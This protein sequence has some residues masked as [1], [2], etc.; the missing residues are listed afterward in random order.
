MPFFHLKC[1]NLGSCVVIYSYKL[2]LSCIPL[3]RLSVNI[4]V[5]FIKLVFQITILMI[6]SYS[7]KI[8]S[9]SPAMWQC[10][11]WKAVWMLSNCHKENWAVY[12]DSRQHGRV[13]RKSFKISCTGAEGELL[14]AKT[15]QV[16]SIGRGIQLWR[17]CTE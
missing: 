9:L 2:L 17:R 15:A 13:A 8:I 5:E 16:P 4:A 7:V 12:S 10:L 3:L 1:Y 14:N 11:F 6:T